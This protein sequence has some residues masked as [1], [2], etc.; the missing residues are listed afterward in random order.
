[1]LGLR[2]EIKEEGVREPLIL[3][4]DGDGLQWVK[5]VPDTTLSSLEGSEVVLLEI[6]CNGDR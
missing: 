5:S 1:M 6:L 4:G 2:G 3:G